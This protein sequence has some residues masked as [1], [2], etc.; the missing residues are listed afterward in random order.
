MIN[1]K[2]DTRL[3]DWWEREKQRR[4]IRVLLFL[5][6]LMALIGYFY[7]INNAGIVVVNGINFD[8]SHHIAFVRQEDNGD[9]A[10]YAIRDDGTDERRLTHADDKSVKSHPAWTFDGKSVLYASNRNDNKV[11]QI[12]VLGSG[13]P[14]QLTYGAGN[15]SF[16]FVVPPDGS[17]A[18]FI[19]QGAIKTVKL[20]GEEVL[21]LLPQPRSTN[22]EDS[23]NGGIGHVEPTGPFLSLGF[24]ADGTGVAGAQDMN[25]ELGGAHESILE[26]QA[27]TCIPPGGGQTVVLA[28]ARGREVSV[29]WEPNGKRLATSFT[30]RHRTDSEK[31]PNSTSF[32]DWQKLTGGKSQASLISG[33][34]IWS[35]DKSGPSPA[36]LFRCEG[37]SMEPKNIAWSPD[38]NNIAFE[39]W[40]LKSEGERELKGIVVLHVVGAGVLVDEAHIDTVQYMLPATADGKPQNPRWSPDGSKILYEMVHPSGKRDLWVINSDGTNPLNLTKGKGDNMDGAWAP[41]KP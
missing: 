4:L 13:E 39:G 30:E 14:A 16:P 2:P 17:H 37:F 9:F 5:F 19:V 24:S 41:L 18:A 31:D 10:L 22:V 8:T 26:D 35:F 32:Q 28:D 15:K 36:T 29:A 11:T 3:P 40:R 23:T 20:N 1:A 33:I 7:Y 25:G 21:Q 27:V 12:Y 6:L 38:G 34:L